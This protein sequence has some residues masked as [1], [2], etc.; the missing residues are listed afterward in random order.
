MND[1]IQILIRTAMQLLAGWLTTHALADDATANQIGSGLGAAVLV[2]A[3]FVWS[4]L[5]L[6]KTADKASAAPVAPAKVIS[7]FLLLSC[8]AFLPG[9]T[10]NQQRIAYNTL[11][12]V[13]QSTTAA[14][15]TYDTLVITGA[16]PTNGVPQVSAAFTKFQ[17]SFLI[18]L[19]AAQFNTNAIAPPALAV[20]A[21]DVINLINTWKANKP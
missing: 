8:P 3:S 14:L 2:A 6:A 9:C 19:D 12:S 18:A 10:T 13:E 11:D 5:H 21:Q 16:L 1:S 17:A 20:E 7:L 15:D 4:K